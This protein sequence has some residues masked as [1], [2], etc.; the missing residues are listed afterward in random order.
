MNAKTCWVLT[1]EKP[2]NEN[3]CRGLA[4]AVGLETAL[5]RV[6][7]RSPWSRLPPQLWFAPLSAPGPGSDP[8]EPPWPDLLIAAGRQTVALSIAIKRASGGRSFTV[9]ILDPAVRLDR[10][11]LVVAPEHDRVSG[12]NVIVT[13]GAMNRVTPERLAATAPAFEKGVAHLPHPRVAVLIGGN[14][15]RHRLDP[16]TA[17]GIGD[18]LAALARANGAGL[19]IIPSRR[20]GDD[21]ARAL[22]ARLDGVAA[23]MWDGRGDNPYFAYLALA[24]A[25]VVT[26]DSVAMVSEACATGKPVHVVDLPGG[27]AK[28]RRFHEGL[29]RAGCTRP[30]GN[31]LASWDY[32]PL[33]ETARVAAEVR[34]RLGLD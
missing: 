34:R 16:A 9:Q 15:K 12:P 3:P 8:L 32:T 7:P 25:I 10:F 2:G 17:A 27:S 33:N 14:S 6:Y 18:R 19:M 31:S 29:R 22:A 23:V 28:F 21:N 13:T 5:K 11:D 26:G 24:D 1:D 30:L 20:T 4:E